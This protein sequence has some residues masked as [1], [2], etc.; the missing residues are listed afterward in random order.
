[1]EHVRKKELTFLLTEDGGQHHLHSWE[2]KLPPFI[3]LGHTFLKEQG[4]LNGFGDL[5]V[6]KKSHHILEDVQSPHW[7]QELCYPRNSQLS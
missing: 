3:F 7:S 4:H 5:E 2:E 6:L 1:M